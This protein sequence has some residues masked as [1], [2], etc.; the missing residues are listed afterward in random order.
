MAGI[1]V[2]GLS[3]TFPTA[4]G[5]VH[6]VRELAFEV[7][8]KELVVVAGPSGCGKTTT[9]RLIA[10]LDRPTAGII[11]IDGKDVTNVPAKD[12]E[13]AMVFQNLALYPHMTAGENIA[14]GLRARKFSKGEITSRLDETVATLGLADCVDRKPSEISGGQRQRVAL[15][16]AIVLR[17]RV[18]L[19]DEPLSNLDGPLRARMRIELSRIQRILGITMIYVTHDQ[20]DAMSL[21]ERLAVMNEGQLRQMA[22]PMTI[23]REPADLFVAGFL[24]APGMNLFPGELVANGDGVVFRAETKETADKETMLIKLP[25]GKAAGVRNAIGKQVVM[26]LRP[27]DISFADGGEQSGI[28]TAIEKVEQLG[29]EQ[30]IHC[31]TAGFTFVVRQNSASRAIVE[32]GSRAKVCFNLQDAHLFDATTGR[33][34]V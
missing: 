9:L 17:P 3:K 23:Y 7:K 18:L 24:G 6:A 29:A 5:E 34:L 25:D 16:R 22:E 30:H 4:R 13:V 21:G 31:R 19:L 26:G 32:D 1:I 15:A 20:I 33:R 10:G 11:R 2:N 8:D 28:E 27:E 12:R 14:F